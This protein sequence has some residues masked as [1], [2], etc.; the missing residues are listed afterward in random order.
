MTRF[1]RYLSVYTKRGQP[2]VKMELIPGSTDKFP[3]LFRVRHRVY[4]I[5][6]INMDTK[7]LR[8][9]RT[10]GVYNFKLKRSDSIWWHNYFRNKSVSDCTVRFRDGR[11][12]L[13]F[14]II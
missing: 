5:P 6:S 12:M 13:S 9:T 10:G 7:Q 2:H 4:N 1:L 14:R 3:N 11:Y 8:I